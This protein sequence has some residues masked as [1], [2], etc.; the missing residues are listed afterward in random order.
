MPLL[1]IDFEGNRQVDSTRLRSLLR[2]LHEG[3]TYRPE[4]MQSEL[5]SIESFYQDE[6]F[7]RAAVGTPLVEF[8]EM[9]GKGRVAVVRVRVFEGP[10]YA[11]ANLQIRNVTALSP[12]T[13]LQMSPVRIGGPYSRRK[14]SEWTQKVMEA[15]HALGYLRADVRLQESVDDLK[16]EVHC[17]LECSEGP[18][19]RVQQIDVVG[20][21]A[22]ARGDFMRRILVG[23]DMPYNPE[24]LTLS[25]QLLNSMGIYRPMGLGSVKVTID[26]DARTVR[27]EFHP[28]PLR[29]Q[30]TS[31]ED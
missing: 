23:V 19:Y 15:Y 28:I 26:D 29:R 21:D 4:A 24:M 25:L 12:G 31:L 27:L 7:L 9:P 8:P 30:G 10:R 13:L 6:G 14:L 5:Q 22:A 1:S 17:V 20:L 16:Y 11:L 18:V 2:F 3:T